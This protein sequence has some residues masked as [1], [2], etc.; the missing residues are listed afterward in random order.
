[1]FVILTGHIPGHDEC[2]VLY[3]TE[4]DCCCHQRDAVMS[5]GNQ[6]HSRDG[7]NYLGLGAKREL[8]NKNILTISHM[9][10][11]LDPFVCKRR[12][13]VSDCFDTV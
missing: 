11:Q 6:P 5:G 4:T 8:K 10:T 7:G 13:C 1:M 9:H 2:I 3:I 12:R